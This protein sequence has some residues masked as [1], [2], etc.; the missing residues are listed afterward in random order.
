MRPSGHRTA[1]TVLVLMAG[2][3]GCGPASSSGHPVVHVA[4]IAP[5]NLDDAVEALDFV[6]ENGHTLHLV[7]QVVR[8]TSTTPLKEV[9]Y[10]RGDLRTNVWSHPEEAF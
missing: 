3:A 7:Y 4:P 5:L 9:W 10:E 6:V 2:F 8:G 1:L